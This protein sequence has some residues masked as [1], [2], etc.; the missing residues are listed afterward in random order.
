MSNEL[1]AHRRGA[2]YHIT[3]RTYRGELR[4]TPGEV[5][6]LFAEGCLAQAASRYGVRIIA[7]VVMGNHFHLIIQVPNH[8]LHA[9]MCYF[10]RE[11]SMRLNLHR[12]EEGTN[13]PVRYRS[14]EIASVE[15]F[16]NEIVRML[17]NPVRARLVGAVE[18][19]PGVSSLG[20]HRSGQ[21]RR[22]VRHASRDQAEV[23]RWDGLT[24]ALERSLH[25]VTLELSRPP[26]WDELDDQ[27]VQA[28]IAELVD[29]EQV[30]LRNEIEATGERVVGPSRLLG[31]MYDRRPD[32]VH[33]RAYRRVISE[34]P[35]YEAR[36]HAWYRQ[37][38]RRYRSAA[39]KWRVEGEWG[40]YPAGTYP[41]GW[42][43]CLPPSGTS[44]PPLPWRE[45]R[46][47]AA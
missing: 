1:R 43:R 46:L 40:S 29:A 3:N 10:Q 9:F 13:F 41:P 2:V 36:Y 33:W 37:L 35:E 14:E 12:G 5:V 16:E 7:F 17:C 45:P 32:A 24:S 8:N 27:Q 23:M 39:R 31:E 38:R 6:N 20:M 30:R 26:F 47:Q 21:R 19:W 44:G 42:L 15:D 28:R 11:L 4:L 34:D 25:E 22:T 18:Q